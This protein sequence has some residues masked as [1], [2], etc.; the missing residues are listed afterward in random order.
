MALSA[1]NGNGNDEIINT[2]ADTNPVQNSNAATLQDFTLNDASRGTKWGAATYG[3]AGGVVKY[4]LWNTNFGDENFSYSSLSDMMKAA[5]RAAFTAWSAVA[6]IDFEEAPDSQ[7]TDQNGIRIGLA[8]LDGAGNTEG[9]TVRKTNADHTIKAAEIAIDLAEGWHEVNGS[10][11]N[12]AG[13]SFYHDVLHEIGHALGLNHYDAGYAIMNSVANAEPNLQRSDID[14]ATFIYGT[15]QPRPNLVVSMFDVGWTFE[16]GKTYKASWSVKNIGNASAGPSSAYLVLTSDPSNIGTI[17]GN[18][19]FGPTDFGL[20]GQGSNINPLA[21]GATATTTN[22]TF[23]IPSTLKPGNYYL[24]IGADFFRE[25]VES[26]ENDNV[27]FGGITI[28]PPLPDLI[29]SSLTPAATSVTQGTAL[30][31]TYVI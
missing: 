17:R 24:G 11:I 19:Y 31:F 3:T 30:D 27:L 14:G 16:V 10:V 12:A 1:G 4:S 15:H 8:P 2:V 21:A 22:F 18:S 5:V 7:T 20:G 6:N 29:V 26:N 9:L 23:T 28:T 13:N 25:V